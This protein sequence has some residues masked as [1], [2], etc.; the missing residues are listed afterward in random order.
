MLAGMQGSRDRWLRLL[1][2]SLRAAC[3]LEEPQLAELRRQFDR[4]L[5][6]LVER[7]LRETREIVG[8]ERL[9]AFAPLIAAA[10]ERLGEERPDLRPWRCDHSPLE[11]SAA[12]VER[13]RAL[14]A[15]CLTASDSVRKRLTKDDGFAPKSPDKSVMLDLL[16]ELGRSPDAARALAR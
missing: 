15:L 9:A 6:F 16:L 8:A 4:D 13:W 10:A 3:A 12:Q 2:G 7:V 14:A 5:R 1:A 11:P